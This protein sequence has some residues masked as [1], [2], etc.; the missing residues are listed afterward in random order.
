MGR[1]NEPVDTEWTRGGPSMHEHCRHS[2]H[3]LREHNDADP[4]AIRWPGRY[5]EPSNLHPLESRRRRKSTDR[6]RRR[7]SIDRMP[8][9]E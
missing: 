1:Y 7:N 2:S 4:D 3:S 9:R 5:V 8:S 6:M